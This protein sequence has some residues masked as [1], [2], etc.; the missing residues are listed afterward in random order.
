MKK[1]VSDTARNLESS[2]IRRFF[3]LANEMEDVISLGVGEPD[4]K[5]AQ[6]IRDKAV[7]KLRAGTTS[8]TPNAGFLKL[9]DCISNHILQ[10]NHVFY[11]PD[12]EIIVTAGS[13]HALDIALRSIINP[14]D[15][16]I[17]IEPTYVAYKPLIELAGGQPVV[18][19][20]NAETLRIDFTQL[21]NSLTKNTKAIILCS[22]NNPT[23]MT[24][25]QAE[26]AV[27]ATLV[28]KY[29]LLVILDEIYAELVYEQSFISFASLKNM[30]KR[31]IVI[32]GFSKGFSMTGWRLGYLCAPEYLVEIMLKIQQYTMMSAPTI[33]QFAAIEALNNTQN[34]VH[35]MRDAYQQRRD[36]LVHSLNQLGLTCQI[37]E[38]AFYVFPS[39]LSTGKTATMF[40]EELLVTNKLAVIPGS[41][42]GKSGE[43]HIRCSYAYSIDTIEKALDRLEKFLVSTN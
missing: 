26:A 23:G 37:P 22:P 39:I 27:F 11:A 25:N 3:S 28:E 31:C 16:I 29:D 42:F 21:E 33:S 20:V 36:Y 8:Y 5:T 10:R 12:K 14:G 2:G 1:Y 9:R 4:F 15:E 34:Y 7:E 43:T 17:V 41:A 30:K 40:C 13:S 32:S 18:V 38:G 6:S 19:E 35:L 24:L